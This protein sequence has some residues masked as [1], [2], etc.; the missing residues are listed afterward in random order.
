M[1][2][3]TDRADV[4]WEP[5]DVRTGEGY[6]H[7][8]DRWPH[9][10]SKVECDKEIA[11][12]IGERDADDDPLWLEARPCFAGPCVVI[13][14]D[15]C[16]EHFDYD[17]SGTM[18]FDPADPMPVPISECDW[19]TERRAGQLDEHYCPECSGEW[20]DEC[21]AQHHGACPDDRLVEPVPVSLD[22]CALPIADLPVG[23]S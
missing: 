7:D 15:E 14:C 21:D 4:C 22:Q 9:Y 18:H 10:S 6:F 23:A 12:I 16:G 3:K 2:I 5:V 17:D 8:D 20:C 19:T 11:E 1:T 13:V